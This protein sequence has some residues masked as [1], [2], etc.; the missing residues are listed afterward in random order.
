[1]SRTCSEDRSTYPTIKALLKY[2]QKKKT[3]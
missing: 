1:M 2:F 3:K